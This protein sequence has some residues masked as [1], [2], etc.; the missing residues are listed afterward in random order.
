[1]KIKDYLD[2]KN[3]DYITQGDNWQM[4]CLFCDDTKQRLGIHKNTGKW[5]CFHCGAKG[6][7]IKSFQKKIDGNDYTDIEIKKITENK[8]LIK[9][10]QD[11]AFKA[12][13]KLL[14]IN[15]QGLKFLKQVR[16]FSTKAINHFILGSFKRKGYEFI[17]IPFFE[18]ETLVNLKFRAIEYSDKKFKW[19]RLKGGKSIIFNDNAIDQ[20]ENDIFLLEAEL[21][22]VSLWDNG[23]K[24]VVS[25]CTGAKGFKPEWYD[26][27]KKFKK[28]Y[29]VF[30]ND[31]AGQEGAE[32]MAHRLGIDRV[33]NILLP[34]DVKDVNEFFWDNEKKEKRYSKKDFNKLIKSAKKFNVKDVMTLNE[35]YSELIRKKTILDEDEIYGLQTPWHKVNKILKG[36]KNG[37]L[38]VVTGNSKTGKTTWVLNWMLYLASMEIRSFMFCCEMRQ[39]RLS[40]KTV[41]MRCKD[42]TTVEDMTVKQIIDARITN[43]G[44]KIYLAYPQNELLNLDNVCKKI[45]DVVKKYGVKFVCFDNL[46][47]LVRGTDIKD[48]IGEITRRFKMLAEQLNIVFCLISHPRKTNSN[49]S[50]TADDLKDSSSIFQDLDNLIIL[51]R[52]R[53]DKDD[54]DELVKTGQMES[55]TELSVV[56]RWG[57]GGN[58][59][60]LFNGERSLFLD[61]GKQYKL[62]CAKYIS[63]YFRKR[64]KT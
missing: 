14:D 60:L 4:N 31:L 10:P 46:H 57:E 16:G 61:D 38:V 63:K 5:N 33:F 29:L 9:I 3:I 34:N 7:T 64:R 45:T 48:K 52:R 41:S 2:S 17:S 32:K 44:D 28:I 23:F 40:E 54:R 43:N 13:K 20:F 58:C 30:D 21:D 50:P 26:R 25:I 27:L 6:S 59:Y 36:S 18:K 49:I 42:F 15:R 53:L 56:S 19:L 37:F 62:E 55:I 24:N 1:M 47:F 39:L 51:H 35:T 22:A 12:R 8:K 11:K